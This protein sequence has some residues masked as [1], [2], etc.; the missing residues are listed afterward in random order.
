[1]SFTQTIHSVE[2]IKIKQFGNGTTFTINY[3]PYFLTLFSLYKVPHQVDDSAGIIQ[4]KCKTIQPLSKFIKT[5]TFNSNK[6]EYIMRL[7]YDMGYIIKTLEN[8]NDSILCVSLDD[9]ILLNDETFF[10]INYEKLLPIQKGYITLKSPICLSN[11]YIS[12]EMNVGQLPIRVYY[13]SFYYS[14]ASMIHSL[15]SQPPLS[16]LH[17]FLQRCLIDNPIERCFVF[18]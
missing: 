13:T 11:S 10:F 15:V 1:M 3:N 6:M 4:F 14:F 16:K 18:I 8:Q 5:S 7:I 17:F 2:S 9:I 12:P